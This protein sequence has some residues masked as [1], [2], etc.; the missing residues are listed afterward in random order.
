MTLTSAIQSC[1]AKAVL[2]VL[3]GGPHSPRS[4]H[5]SHSDYIA[6]LVCG[7]PP[8]PPILYGGRRTYEP[9]IEIL[10]KIY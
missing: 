3:A 7:M 2:M 5:T 9:I 6:A 8:Q 1:V 10:H 4:V